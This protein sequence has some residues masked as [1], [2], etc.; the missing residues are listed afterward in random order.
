M[1]NSGFNSFLWGVIDAAG[2]W[3]W[4]PCWLLAIKNMIW[5]SLLNAPVTGIGRAAR[6][7][8]WLAHIP[9]GFIP[10]YNALGCVAL[11]LLLVASNILYI[12]LWLSCREQRKLLNTHPKY[13]ARRVLQSMVAP[14]L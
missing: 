12:Q 13:G 5:L 4:I 2:W 9:M 14:N 11:P 7:F 10:L 6:T 1:T 3:W 8:A